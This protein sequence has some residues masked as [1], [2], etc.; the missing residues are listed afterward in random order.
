MIVSIGFYQ[1]HSFLPGG[2]WA[3]AASRPKSRRDRDELLLLVRLDE[4]FEGVHQ[5]GGHL[6]QLPHQPIELLYPHLEPLQS[7]RQILLCH[8]PHL[9]SGAWAPVFSSWEGAEASLA[10]LPLTCRNERG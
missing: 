2:G 9:L 6:K 3:A 8:G 10:L 1:D 5:L 4:R 7:L